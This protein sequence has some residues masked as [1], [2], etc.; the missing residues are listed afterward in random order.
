MS[1]FIVG[2]CILVSRLSS[3]FTSFLVQQNFSLYPFDWEGWREYFTVRDRTHKLCFAFIAP[4]LTH[5]SPLMRSFVLLPIT[6]SRSCMYGWI[7]RWPFLLIFLCVELLGQRQRATTGLDCYSIVRT[8]SR[9][10]CFG[11]L[12]CVC[13]RSVHVCMYPC[14]FM[15]ITIV[16]NRRCSEHKYSNRDE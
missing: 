5:L 7:G 16:T 8:V 6:C 3:A 2:R 12:V 15:Y 14:G 1:T 9:L 13:M 11:T 10:T 4:Y